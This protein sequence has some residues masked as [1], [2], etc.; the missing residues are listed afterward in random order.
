VNKVLLVLVMASML[1]SVQ[2]DERRRSGSDTARH[3]TIG[4]DGGADH[5]VGADSIRGTPPVRGVP[6]E[7]ALE[8]YW[9]NKCVQQRAR[10]WGHTGDC[11]SPAYTGGGRDLYR[12]SARRYGRGYGRYPGPS[13]GGYDPYRPS[14]PGS[15]AVIIV[16]GKRGGVPYDPGRSGRSGFS[17]SR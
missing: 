6:V 2:A 17:G 5:R 7:P 10:G 14:Y 3:P 8:Q 12:R 1:T 15:E 11:D 9:S 4:R 16:P 13:A